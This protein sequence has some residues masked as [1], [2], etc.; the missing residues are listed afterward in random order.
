MKQKLK[1]YLYVLA[2]GKSLRI[3]LTKEKRNFAHRFVKINGKIR[4]QKQQKEN[5]FMNVYIVERDFMRSQVKIKNTVQELVMIKRGVKIKMDNYENLCAYKR[6]M[7][8][9]N[10]LLICGIISTEDYRKIDKI[11]AD[12]Y[13]IN[14]CSIYRENA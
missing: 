5:Y 12:K 14:S 9:A 8:I 4:I 13:G 10:N 1:N 3:Y 11:I 7:L 6:T 2:A